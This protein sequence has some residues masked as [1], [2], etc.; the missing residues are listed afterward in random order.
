MLNREIRREVAQMKTSNP[1][2]KVVVLVALA[3]VVLAAQPARVD[4]DEIKLP[5][6]DP[7][8]GAGLINTNPN[9]GDDPRVIHDRD[10][11][12]GGRRDVNL[13]PINSL[14]QIKLPV[15]DDFGFLGWLMKLRLLLGV[16]PA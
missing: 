4:A 2:T 7:N 16:S 1:L 6:D 14:D 10:Y 12:V 3:A 13:G 15:R 9:P 11:G 8:Y 5:V